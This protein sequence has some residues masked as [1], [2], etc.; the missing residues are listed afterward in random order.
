MKN[1]LWLVLVYL[2]IFPYSD[3]MHNTHEDDDKTPLTYEHDEPADVSV[4]LIDKTAG[5]VPTAMYYKIVDAPQGFNKWACVPASSPEEQ[6]MLERYRSNKL[7]ELYDK[8][9]RLIALGALALLPVDLHD[10]ADIDQYVREHLLDPD[11]QN[12]KSAACLL[13]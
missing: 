9:W 13:M 6:K 11:A 3:A 7:L 5:V 10:S 12:D 4:I 8:N 1:I 2:S